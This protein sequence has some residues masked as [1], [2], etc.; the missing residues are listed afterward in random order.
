MEELS[1]FE[2]GTPVECFLD[3]VPLKKAAAE[4]IYLAL[5]ECIQDNN[6]QVGNIVGMGFDVLPS[7]LVM[8]AVQARLKNAHCH[9]QLLQL[10]CVQ[11]VNS[12]TGIKHVYS[13]LT[14][15]WKY[16]HYSPKRAESLK[17]IQ[18]V[19]NLPEMKVI[20][21]PDTRWLAHEQR[22]K[23]V[24]VSYTALVVTLDSNYHNFHAPEALGLY[25]ALSKSITIAA[26]I[27]R[28]KLYH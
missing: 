15:L 23:A 7:F 9:C 4:S 19:L 6:L 24:K 11:T 8:T 12:T 14:T 13:T 5:V 17:E 10:A 1:A 26:I 25:K 20:K 18:H 16:F 28:I 22:I 27:Y 3:I 2:D 21:P